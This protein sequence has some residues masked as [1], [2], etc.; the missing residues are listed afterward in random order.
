MKSFCIHGKYSL[1]GHAVIL[2]HDFPSRN[3]QNCG[4]QENHKNNGSV[5]LE[6]GD[7]KPQKHAE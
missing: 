7:F 2:K 1:Y 6:D 3:L 5:D 4:N